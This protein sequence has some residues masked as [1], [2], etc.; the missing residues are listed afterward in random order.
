MVPV[1]KSSRR[2]GL[3]VQEILTSICTKWAVLILYELARGRTRHGELQRA[4]RGISQKMLT[5]TLRQLER[6][7]L[8]RRTVY[9]VVPPRV[10]YALTPLGTTLMQP[11]NALYRW[12][13]RSLSQIQQARRASPGATGGAANL[14]LDD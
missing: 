5:R 4:I 8:V 11:L 14:R 1:N 2:R 12:T 3:D 13:E 10:D 9:P 6:D 7:R